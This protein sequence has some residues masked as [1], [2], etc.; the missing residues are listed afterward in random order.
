MEEEEEEEE[1]EKEEEEEVVV[2]VVALVSL[3]SS[4][5]R[6]TVSSVSGIVRTVA[7]MHGDNISELV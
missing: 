2:V 7:Y 6:T 1:E 3:A 5:G 4:I